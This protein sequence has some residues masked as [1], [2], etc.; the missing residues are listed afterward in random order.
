M[1]NDINLGND[2]LIEIFVRL[3]D[4]SSLIRCRLVSKHWFSLINSKEYSYAKQVHH[5]QSQSLLPTTLLFWNNYRLRLNSDK[6]FY[7]F[8]TDE[9]RNFYG[10]TFSNFNYFNFLPWNEVKLYASLNDLLLLLCDKESFIICNP[11]TKQWLE[12]PKIPL[13]S[14]KRDFLPFKG[15]GGLV[16]DTNTNKYKVV[17]VYYD[18]SPDIFHYIYYVMT[19][20]FETREWSSLFFPLTFAVLT[21]NNVTCNGIQHC[22]VTSTLFG[23]ARKIITIDS[24]RGHIEQNGLPRDLKRERGKCDAIR[25]RIGVVR[26]QLRLSQLYKENNVFLLKIWEFNFDEDEECDV[27]YLSSKWSLVHEVNVECFKTRNLRVVSFHPDDGNL[28]FLLQDSYI[29]YQYDIVRNKFSKVGQFP[30][31]HWV[32]SNLITRKFQVH[33]LL[34]PLF[35]TPLPILGS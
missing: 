32:L 12:L 19:F 30:F 6:L 7:T 15:I 26:E 4:I 25:V 8:L 29:I 5:L 18:N 33:T 27:D 35:P 20:D 3:K 9:S 17:L 11:L 10:N 1:I 16:C 22:L 2:I 23:N 31:I 14:I 13:F 28:I 34:H 24:Y 21:E